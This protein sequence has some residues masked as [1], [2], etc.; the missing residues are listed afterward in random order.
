MFDYPGVAHAVLKHIYLHG[1]S[2]VIVTRGQ[3]HGQIVG[4]IPAA[5]WSFSSLKK[6]LLPDP[7]RRIPYIKS[8][9]KKVWQ[10]SIV[11]KTEHN[12]WWDWLVRS[13][14]SSLIPS[15]GRVPDSAQHAPGRKFRKA[16]R[17]IGKFLTCWN[18][19][20]LNLWGASTN[21]EMVVEMQL[22]S[23]KKNMHVTEKNNKWIY[24][25]WITELLNQWI[26]ESMNQWIS[27]PMK[28]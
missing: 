7:G 5:R 17:P 12:Q 6:V 2:W 10:I 9:K 8:A 27:E 25:H 13:L 11:P 23:D 28:Q 3:G 24:E 21:D 22:K 14:W 26:N 4:I 16:Y 19:E 18:D 1:Q 20:V 15:M